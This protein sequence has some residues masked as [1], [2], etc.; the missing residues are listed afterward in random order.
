MGLGKRKGKPPAGWFGWEFVPEPAS[1]LLA[2]GRVPL[3]VEEREGAGRVGRVV[4]RNL[5]SGFGQLNN[6]LV[7]VTEWMLPCY[8]CFLICGKDVRFTPCQVSSLW[9]DRQLN[10][11]LCQHAA[12]V[13]RFLGMSLLEVTLCEACGLKRKQVKQQHCLVPYLDFE[14]HSYQQLFR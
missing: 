5:P 1:Q 3:K 14:T 12:I 8:P 7:T 11:D 6:F 10:R 9:A 13:Q 2:K 4:G